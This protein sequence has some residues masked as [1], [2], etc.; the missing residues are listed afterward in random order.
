M[1]A[2]STT[3]S[4]SLP[5]LMSVKEVATWLRTT[6]AAVYKLQERRQLPQAVRVGNRLL[7]RESD[8]IAWLGERQAVSPS[9]G[10]ERCQ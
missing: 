1:S 10:D 7:F 2:P 3:G 8:L 4:P 6:E 9:K 5:R